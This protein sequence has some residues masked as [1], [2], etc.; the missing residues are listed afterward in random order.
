MAEVM[1]E[2]KTRN[3]MAIEEVEGWEEENGEEGV[4]GQEGG[5]LGCREGRWGDCLP[6]CLA[7][8]CYVCVRD[9]QCGK[10]IREQ[11]SGVGE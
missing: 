3:P 8:V 10:E 5:F 9:A 1:A 2:D 6:A 11:C 4:K 7:G